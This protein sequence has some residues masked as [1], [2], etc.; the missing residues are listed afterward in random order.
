MEDEKRD[1]VGK[2]D[3]AYSET[4]YDDAFRTMEGKCDDLVIPLVNVM[5][6]EKYSKNAK[7]KRLRNEQFIERENGAGEKRITDSSFEITDNDITK[8]YHLECESKKYDKFLLVRLF[9]Y[10]SEIALSGGE[11]E[12][13]SFKVKF[14]NTG[15]LLLR[16][17]GKDPK[18]GTITIEMPDGE[19]VSYN[20]PILRV[21]DF[22]IDAIFEKHL[23]MLI[24]FY[25]FTFENQLSDID[26]DSDR[27]DTLL[28]LY[29]D[30]YDRLDEELEA[31]NLSALSLSAIIKLM[32][33]VAYKL[34]I[35][36][37][38]LNKRVGDLMNGKILD[39]PEFKVHD[40]ALAEGIAIGEAER[41]ALADE[42]DALAD[43][44]KQLRQ[45]LNE[46]DALADENK[47]LRRELDALKKKLPK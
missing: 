36:K 10:D 46:R 21:S 39:L 47:E 44:N 33:R 41:K 40:Q 18:H 17:S 1:N 11:N 42:R 43:E 9:E 5:F 30:I 38:N 35:K 45:E 32:Y 20:I 2:E 6:K 24:P 16:S 29:L 31:G 14:P 13:D 34:T 7:V 22:T 8:K 15:I 27:I 19:V 4:A 3:P 23:Y 37:S 25:I 28:N 12:V 26:N